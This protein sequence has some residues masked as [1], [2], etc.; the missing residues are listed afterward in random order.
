[1]NKLDWIERAAIENMKR[2]ADNAD[3]SHDE[4]STLLAIL[5]SG[6]GAT[7]YFP[8]KGTDLSAVAFCV[9]FWLFWSGCICDRDVL[10]V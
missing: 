3:L 6:G 9:S 7:L 8:A 5:L 4:A 2:R 1:M 10:D